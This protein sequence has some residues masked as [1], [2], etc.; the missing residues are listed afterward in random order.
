MSVSG[1]TLARRLVAEGLGTALLLATVV[2]SGIMA[3]RLCGGNVG[4]ALLANALATGAGLE[5]RSG[6][7][8]SK[9][10]RLRS[11]MSGI[12][13]IGRVPD[14]LS[15]PRTWEVRWRSHGGIPRWN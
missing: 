15:P 3:E 14:L 5:Q 4:L 7:K 8:V 2:G 9:I 10:D 13:T 6:R 1:S 11:G 12:S